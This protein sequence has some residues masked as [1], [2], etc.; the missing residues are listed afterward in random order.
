[1]VRHS[2]FYL[3]AAASLCLGFAAAEDVV[4]V[5]GPKEFDAL[6]KDNSFVVAEFFAPWYVI[7]PYAGHL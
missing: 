1:M 2:A 7:Y 5:S 3:A 6:L 4:V